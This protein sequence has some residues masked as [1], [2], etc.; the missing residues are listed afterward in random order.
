MD[1][2][3]LNDDYGIRQWEEIGKRT[4]D[5]E[6]ATFSTTFVRAAEPVEA[7]NPTVLAVKSIS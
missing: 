7:H 2:S 4:V 3:S 5:A 6:V 1:V